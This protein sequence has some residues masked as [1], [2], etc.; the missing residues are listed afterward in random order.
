VSELHDVEL[1]PRSLKTAFEDLAC[2]R[3]WRLRIAA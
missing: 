2:C 3:W 1:R